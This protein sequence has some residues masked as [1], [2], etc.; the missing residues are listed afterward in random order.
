MITIQV[1]N[2]KI[3]SDEA[4]SVALLTNF[5][6]KKGKQV[7]VIRSRDITNADIL[8]DV[9][10][11]YNHLS[12]RYDHHQNNFTE[13]WS[14][15]DKIYLSSVGLIWRHY[16]NEIVEMYLSENSEQY[17][18]S[19]NYTEDTIEEIKNIIYYKLIQ[20][21][22]ADDNGIILHENSPNLNIPSII[23][24]LNGDTSDEVKQNEKFYRAVDLIGDIFD[25]KFKEII[26]SYFNFQK[27]LETVSTLN[28]EGPCL[29]VDKNIP[30]IFKCVNQLD[31]EQKIK[32]CI[33]CNDNEFT[34]KT[35]RPFEQKFKP[36]CPIAPEKYLREKMGEK[37]NDIIFIHK[38]SFM[39]KTKTLESAIKIAELSIFH[40]LINVKYEVP[41]F[42]PINYEKIEEAHLEEKEK[43][44]LLE[45]K[46]YNKS[47][48]LG[49]CLLGLG[50][51][52]YKRKD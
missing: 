26:N 46:R 28:L 15:E 34:I 40:N 36:L 47:V 27:D 48:I 10:L 35:V 31:K 20:E 16:G 30:T 51:Y 13:T 44:D 50:L 37:L 11:E 1:H 22:D 41:E 19:F 39:A 2:G 4:A 5:F 14:P 21:L 32:F 9:G 29:I 42:K 24:S 25:I 17:D 6:A 23:S 33:F 7:S 38:G 49:F 8:V 3:H 43:H 12:L 18:Y 45:N 52:L